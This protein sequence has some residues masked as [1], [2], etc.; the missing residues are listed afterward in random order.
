[1]TVGDGWML[2][3][4]GRL[5]RDDDEVEPGDIVAV[6]G[7]ELFMSPEVRDRLGLTGLSDAD[8]TARLGEMLRDGGNDR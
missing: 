5:A 4:T 1:M 6:E 7:F 8:A 3:S 2:L